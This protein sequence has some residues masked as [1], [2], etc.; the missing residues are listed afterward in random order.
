[1][2]GIGK[3]VCVTILYS[4]SSL[5]TRPEWVQEGEGIGKK[6]VFLFTSPIH[7]LVVHIVL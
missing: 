7:V 5:F 2:G 4:Y 3:E 1:M 6:F